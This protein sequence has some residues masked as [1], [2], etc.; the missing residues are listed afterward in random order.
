VRHVTSDRP[1]RKMSKKDTKR[2][3][4]IDLP[5][6]HG[7]GRR[8]FMQLAGF[9]LG[10]AGLTGCMRG[11]E[12]GVVPYLDRPEE[13]T[14][15]KAYWY[16]SVCGGCAAGCGMLSKDRD[17]RPIKLEGNPDH[18]LSGG[19]LCAIGQ[20]SVLALYDSQRLMEPLKDGT[21]TPWSVI[22][23]EIASRLQSLPRGR[24]RF[25][26]DSLTGPTEREAIDGFL[27]RFP[28]GR[29]V[30][31]D[32][33]SFSAIPD[34]HEA[35]H[36]RR[37][38]PH[39]R[40]ENARTIVA[41]HADFLGGW[42][43]P[44]E[45]TAA[46]SKGRRLEGDAAGFSRHIQFESRMTLTGS[47]ADRRFTIPAGG[48]AV[49]LA[50]IADT[51]ARKRGVV[52]PWGSPPACPI[53]ADE[54]ESVV[55]ELEHAGP[56]ASLVVCGENDLTAQ[57]LVNFINHLLGNYGGTAANT[58]L[59][60]ERVSRQYHGSESQLR[61]LL[62]EIEAG[63]VD[64]LFLRGVNPCY[65]LPEGGQLAEAMRKIPLVIHFSDQNNETAE[66][67]AYVCPEPH[68]LEAW[69]DSEPLS[70]VA[71]LRQPALRAIG[72]TRPMMASL[73]VW[74]GSNASAYEQLRT[75][76][77][78]RVYPRRKHEMNFDTFWNTALHDG[79]VELRSPSPAAGYSYT[80]DASSIATPADGMMAPEGSLQIE[81]HAS[82]AVL[83][84][85]HAHNAWL[86]EMPDPITKTVWANHVA[87]SPATAERSGV[88]DGDVVRL[89][90]ENTSME[91]PVLIQPGQDD[92]CA[93]IA[94]GYGRSGTD[95]FAEVGP[96]WWEGKLTVEP[97]QT[98]GV[99]AAPMIVWDQ[100]VRVMSGRPVRLER[101]DRHEPLTTTQLHHTLE[102]PKRLSMGEGGPRPIIQETTLAAWRK[103]PHSGAHVEHEQPSLWPD[104][105]KGPH[106]WGM[107]IDLSACT[108]C[109]A[110]VIAC[111]VE[112]NIPVVGRD[113]VSR[114]REMHW[115]RIDRYYDGEGA[116][117][118]VVHMPMLCQH[119]DN[120]P[121]E[122]VCPVQAT[123][124]SAEGLNQQIYNRCVGTRYCA[125]NCP[126]KVRR[127]NWF[128]YPRE[129][130][131]QNLL[132]NPDVTVRSR[133]VMEKCS[134]CVQRIQN[135]KAESKRT[136][137]PLQDGAIQ[138]ACA[139][140]CPAQAIV[141]GDS[142]DPD[143]QLTAKKNDARHFTVLAELA[144]KP[145]VGYMTLVRN[146]A[147]NPGRTEG[148]H[149]DE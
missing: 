93:A 23:E 124:Q 111:Q 107:T 101:T 134:F 61:A 31:Y 130:A 8:E 17:G 147:D 142:K 88:S 5:M 76:W 63:A 38:L 19:A 92:G 133:G 139:Q 70:G 120:A 44:V 96:Q 149:N 37:F 71:A 140:S 53:G 3:R 114:A 95:R 25:L 132:L 135:G 46:Y 64:A 83:D 67:S 125:N 128:T 91:L 14:P 47:K 33:I 26:V 9:S 90:G 145:V 98:I 22:D 129:D 29:Q 97:G 74:S 99:S 87:I 81:L 136:G 39:Y 7:L 1:G 28:D 32:S 2:N 13:I 35:T 15:G 73:A 82:Y 106:H 123:A 72:S 21:K 6:T 62:D 113:E 118:D 54:I 50:H 80:F 56:G 42:L 75:A 69:G 60:T 45:Y 55:L 103:N 34:A 102:I 78:R 65:D 43:S 84:G 57:K 20:A 16:A 146:R 4:Q 27:R 41:V 94:V 148:S 117:A 112:N 52:T 79:V 115:M 144:V 58:T 105:P 138:P 59:D 68:F 116:N 143:S 66:R 85:R 49:L 126:Y 127:F 30:S 51:L 86:H 108:G 104:H 12:H 48:S 121:C 18:P 137:I 24:V 77:Q 89:T 131:L 10:A 40:F 119:C 141:F 100:G 110:C 11:Q 109:S 122:T 36:G